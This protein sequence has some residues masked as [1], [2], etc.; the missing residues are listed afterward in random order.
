MEE[1]GETDMTYTLDDIYYDLR[2]NS[3]TT[4]ITIGFKE[5]LVIYKENGLP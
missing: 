4:N 1:V 2:G 3:Y 5:G